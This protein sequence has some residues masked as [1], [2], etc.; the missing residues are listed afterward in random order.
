MF[1]VRSHCC[2]VAI[3]PA[4]PR[5]PFILL[6][7]AASVHYAPCPPWPRNARTT[8]ATPAT[9]TATPNSVRSLFSP[10]RCLIANLTMPAGASY[11]STVARTFPPSRPRSRTLLTDVTRLYHLP[12]A[13]PYSTLRAHGSRQETPRSTSSLDRLPAQTVLPD[14]F[15]C[16][17]FLYGT[18][19]NTDRT[20]A[21]E[22][23]ASVTNARTTAV[24][25]TY[26]S[27]PNTR[28][29]MQRPPTV[30]SNGK[31]TLTPT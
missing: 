13:R 18:T 8:I 29:P 2:S 10:A 6:T 1:A 26:S 28:R 17:S 4:L 14:A 11:R 31:L 19:I 25:A 15:M 16:V 23:A 7:R 24:C 5:P 20:S 3:I 22:L 30:D 9:T 12:L 27:R 21:R